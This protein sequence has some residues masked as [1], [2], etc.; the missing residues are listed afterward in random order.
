MLR[1]DIK[2]FWNK[3]KRFF[4]FF[5]DNKRTKSE[6]FVF[7]S[8]TSF[9]IETFVLRFDIVDV[10]LLEIRMDF[11]VDPDPAFNL[12]VDLDPEGQTNA[13]V[14]VDPDPGQSHLKPC[15]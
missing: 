8:I 11:N 15:C 9:D 3:L 2:N 4:V 14:H 10:T 12:N 5:S 1:F 7:A 13:G 6:R